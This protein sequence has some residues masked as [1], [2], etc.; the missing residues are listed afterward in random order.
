[1]REGEVL[2]VAPLCLQGGRAALALDTL[3]PPPA[4]ECGVCKQMTDKCVI[5]QVKGN[6]LK[7]TADICEE[8]LKSVPKAR[9]RPA[10]PP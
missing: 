1:M 8:A 5:D 10:R 7:S 6:S 4:Q 3:F 9:A 2:G